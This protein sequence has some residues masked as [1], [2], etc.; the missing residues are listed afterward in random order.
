[1]A[2]Y[3]NV[4]LPDHPLAASDGKVSA[5]RLALWDKIGDGEHP[6]HWCGCPLRWLPGE[7]NVPGAITADHLDNDGKNNDPANLVPSCHPCNVKRQ[8]GDRPSG[9][10]VSDDE[11]FIIFKNGTRHRAVR[12]VCERCGGE[13]LVLAA[14]KR[15][16]RG[17]F[18]SVDC[19]WGR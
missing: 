8:L 9:P 6:C 17:R 18:C 1:M 15:P 5:H 4:Y 7:G 3:L 14:E 2:R 12:K 11:P 16:N 10:L 19:R 13:V